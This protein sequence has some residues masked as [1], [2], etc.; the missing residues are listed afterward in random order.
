MTPSLSSPVTS[1]AT[2]F[3]EWVV[4]VGMVVIVWAVSRLALWGLG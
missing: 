2:A 1:T 3:R 4:V